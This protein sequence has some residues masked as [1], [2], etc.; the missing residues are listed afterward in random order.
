MQQ[1]NHHAYI[2]AKLC[3]R[4][5]VGLTTSLLLISCGVSVNERSKLQASIDTFVS[6]WNAANLGSIYETFEPGF[7]KMIPSQDFIAWKRTI[8]SRWGSL[9]SVRILKAEPIV[10]KAKYYSV[11]TEMNYDK[12]K[13]K[14]HFDFVVDDRS[15]L[16][17]VSVMLETFGTD[18]DPYRFASNSP[19]H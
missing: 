8:D 14:G 15:E 12:G 9:R 1:F 19:K 13:T 17:V 2:L 6:Q 16:A 7:K 10:P 4:L 3:T 5:S 11:D 18:A